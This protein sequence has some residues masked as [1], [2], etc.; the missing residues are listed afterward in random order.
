MIYNADPIVSYY[1]A[2]R[3]RFLLVFGPLT[4]KSRIE[5]DVIGKESRQRL[6]R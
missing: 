3:S 1:V 2:S 6:K 4:L 5:L